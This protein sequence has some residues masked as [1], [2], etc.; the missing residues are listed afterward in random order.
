MIEQKRHRLDRYYV[1]GSH[2]VR[3][4]SPLKLVVNPILRVLQF[5]TN[6]PYVI[7]SKSE[8]IS[9][10]DYKFIG[11]KFMR[12]RYRWTIFLGIGWPIA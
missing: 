7:A 5:W 8:R 10:C 1:V 12:V 11:Y 9:Y 2:G 4:R 6:N 3:H